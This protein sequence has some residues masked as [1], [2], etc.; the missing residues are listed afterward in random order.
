MHSG[1]S[2]HYM[3]EHYTAELV[4]VCSNLYRR[5]MVNIDSSKWTRDMVEP[6]LSKHS[7]LMRIKRV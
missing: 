2:G 3:R 5:P 1:T 6:R 4:F 7:C